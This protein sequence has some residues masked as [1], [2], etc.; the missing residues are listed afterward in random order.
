MPLLDLHQRPLRNLRVSVTDRC[1]LRCA[2]CM[3]EEQ[4]RWLPKEDVLTFEETARSRELALEGQSG[5]MQRTER[6][7]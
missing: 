3:P 7:G 2:Y 1:N 5:E 4:Y 6:R